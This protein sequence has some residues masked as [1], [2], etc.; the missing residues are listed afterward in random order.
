MNSDRVNNAQAARPEPE[1]EDLTK[2]LNYPAIGE[3]FSEGDSRRLEDFCAR[4]TATRAELERIVR[5]G[6]RAEAESAG[7][8]A[9]AVTVTLDFLRKLQQMRLSAER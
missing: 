7:R 6:S 1:T 8:A 9:R 2:L 3:L 5:Y 4:L